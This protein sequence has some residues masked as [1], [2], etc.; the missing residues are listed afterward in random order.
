M[1]CI[2]VSSKIELKFQLSDTQKSQKKFLA[3]YEIR[4]LSTV[5]TTAATCP[6]LTQI[7]PINDLAFCFFKIHC[8]IP[9][10]LWVFQVDPFRFLGQNVVCISLPPPP[11]HATYLAHL[12]AL[13]WSFEK[14][15]V[16]NTHHEGPHYAF[17]FFLSPNNSFLLCSG[18]FHVP[19]FSNTLSL[20]SSLSVRQTKFYTHTK[21][22]VHIF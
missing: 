14:Y 21:F 16:R 6:Y 11:P 13:M 10:Y 12:I 7:C 1:T 17:F 2:T 5:F 20:C 19:I 3:F 18:I 15:L 8:N 22:Y 4:K 9:I